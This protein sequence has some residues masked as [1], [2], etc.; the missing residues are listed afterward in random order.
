[1]DPHLGEVCPRGL[2]HIE[3]IKSHHQ[4]QEIKADEAGEASKAPPEH[5]DVRI[6]RRPLSRLPPSLEIQ[7][8]QLGTD[9]VDRAADPFQEKLGKR[10]ILILT[11]FGMIPATLCTHVCPS[12]SSD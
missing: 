3:E 9:R 7:A 4:V 2:E 1:M 8:R 5:P 11:H 10:A 6:V 12:A